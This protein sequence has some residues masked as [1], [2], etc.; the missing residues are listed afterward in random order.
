M[1]ADAMMKEMTGAHVMAMEQDVPALQ[2]MKPGG[3]AHPIDR[4]LHDGDQVTLGG[5]TLVARLTPGHTKGCTTWTMKAQD[6]GRSYDVVIIGSMGVN[7]GTRLV[8]NAT[9]PTIADEYLQGFKVMRS[10]PV[11]VPLGSHPG[12]YNMAAKH[13]KLSSGGRNPYIDP[14]GYNAEIDLVEA[15][16]KSVLAEQQ[17]AAQ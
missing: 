3:K 6:G 12:M 14:Q 5:T 1:E 8:N 7:P 17:K 16:F 15:T 4:I 9:N 11:D 2:A 10:L 13:A